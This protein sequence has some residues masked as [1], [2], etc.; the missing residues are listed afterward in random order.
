VKRLLEAIRL[1]LKH[2]GIKGES[3]TDKNNLL[4]ELALD[5]FKLLLGIQHDV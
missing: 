2:G 4:A 5:N 3:Q 1:L